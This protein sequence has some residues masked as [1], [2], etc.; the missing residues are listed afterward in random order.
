MGYVHGTVIGDNGCFVCLTKLS[1][2]CWR[3]N[4]TIVSFSYP[5]LMQIDPNRF[6]Q[7]IDAQFIVDTM[8][9]LFYGSLADKK[10]MGD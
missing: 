9:V 1:P 8:S 7:A 5:W 6:R 4:R 3:S 10:A 2:K